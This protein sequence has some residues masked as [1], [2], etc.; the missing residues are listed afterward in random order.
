MKLGKMKQAFMF[1]ESSLSNPV[2]FNTEGKPVP[3]DFFTRKYGK[4]ATW[5]S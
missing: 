3:W 5:A 1:L 2:K 4:F